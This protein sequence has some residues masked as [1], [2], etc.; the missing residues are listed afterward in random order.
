M[1]CWSIFCGVH[2]QGQWG[3]FFV[4]LSSGIQE[5]SPAHWPIVELW[6][7]QVWSESDQIRM[8]GLCLFT[9]QV[10]WSSDCCPICNSAIPSLKI[11]RA[12]QA[13]SSS[14]QSHVLS[15]HPQALCILYYTVGTQWWLTNDLLTSHHRVTIFSFYLFDSSLH[16][17]YLWRHFCCN[18]MYITKQRSCCP[19]FP[20]SS[21][22]KLRCDISLTFFSSLLNCCTSWYCHRYIQ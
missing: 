19:P 4:S 10:F 21:V 20:Q 7:M 17:C 12:L 11:Q 3:H 14:M 13:S 18:M 5:P 2:Q 9:S 22:M 8:C 16:L 15:A 1:M 6:L